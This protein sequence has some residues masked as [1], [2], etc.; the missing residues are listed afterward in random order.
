MFPS[1]PDT[2]DLEPTPYIV[3]RS[4][5]FT[6]VES[7]LEKLEYMIPNMLFI[8]FRDHLVERGSVHRPIHWQTRATFSIWN[9]VDGNSLELEMFLWWIVIFAQLQRWSLCFLGCPVEWRHWRYELPLAGMAPWAT[10]CIWNV[11]DGNWNL[12]YFPGGLCMMWYFAVPNV[13]L[14][15]S[16]LPTRCY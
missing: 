1:M 14:M 16:G 4:W 6:M 7:D 3:I 9:V 13:F 10:F 15:F 11:V 8:C 2:T 12:R 5:K